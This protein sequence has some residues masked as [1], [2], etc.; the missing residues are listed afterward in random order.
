MKYNFCLLIPL[1]LL[2]FYCKDDSE[3][4]NA[5][6]LKEAK[7][8][9]LVFATINN[10]WKLQ[11]VVFS[12]A[13]QGALANWSEWRLFLSELNQKPKSTIGAFQKKAKALSQ[14]AIDLNK[15]I[16][17]QF[18]KP[19]IKSRI[20]VLITKVNSL[21]L[22]INLQNIPEQKV[23]V[24]VGEINS[25]LASLCQQMEEINKKNNIPKEEGE[26]DMIRM[27]DKTRAIPSQN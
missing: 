9:E 17:V 18:A 8:K 7:K 6:N 1:I 13:V 24:L 4:R 22:F 14:K 21:Y 2:L 10:G 23:L 12:P 16:P 19:E 27:L 20:S 5:E 11:T 25:E 15:N 3:I 26:A